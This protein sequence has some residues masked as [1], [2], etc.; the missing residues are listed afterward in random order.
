MLALAV[1]LNFI[2]WSGRTT[3]A[4]KKNVAGEGGEES[5]KKSV[6]WC[7]KGRGLINE[8]IKLVVPE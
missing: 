2:L 4:Q 6:R 7:A 3:T 5:F 8:D 1:R